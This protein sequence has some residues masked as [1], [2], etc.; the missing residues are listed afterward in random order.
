MLITAEDGGKLDPAAG[1]E[2]AA[3]VV[4]RMK[5]LDEEGGRR[6]PVT[7]GRRRPSFLF[8]RVP[9]RRARDAVPGN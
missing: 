9:G 1:R 8:F 2:A 5:A 4:E 6:D 7:P 3:D